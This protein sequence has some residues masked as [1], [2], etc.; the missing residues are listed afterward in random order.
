MEVSGAAA[1]EILLIK[2]FDVRWLS[3]SY[4]TADAVYKSSPALVAQL[5]D[6]ADNAATSKDRA[7]ARGMA[8]KMQSRLLVAEAALMRDILDMLKTLSLFLQ[9]RLASIMEA[10]GQ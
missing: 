4:R 3:S 5:L 7:K 8:N 10:K 2:I 1:A 6:S 9:S